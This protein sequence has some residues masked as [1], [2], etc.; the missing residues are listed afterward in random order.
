M[1]VL[2]SNK[3]IVR[4][5]K[6]GRP[7]MKPGHDGEFMYTGC[8]K[9][10]KL[11]YVLATRSFARIFDD[12]EQKEFEKL[13]NKKEGEL[14][15]YNWKSEFWNDF[16]VELGKEEKI[17]DLNIP[18]HALEYRVLKANSDKIAVDEANIRS[19]AH[20]YVL[21][22]ENAKQEADYKLSEKNE[23]AMELFMK[24]RKS[25]KKMYDLLRVLGKNPSHNMKSNTK[26]LKAELDA[27]IAQKERINGQVG[28]DDFIEAAKDPKFS[29][30]IF[31]LDAVEL[32]EILTKNGGYRIAET[33]QLIGNS[34]EQAVDF[35]D[36]A[37][38]QDQ[39]LLIEQRL[40]LNK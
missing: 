21:V 23:E 39:K 31:V 24:L 15:I 8:F 9:G 34:L 38:N 10:Y 1:S 3:V 2:N 5:V 6:S 30:K 37:K 17:L 13:L 28:I 11:P 27:V 33:K 22:D 14:S 40:Q 25:D 36:D 4:P 29:T 20:S 7:F 16:T 26:A 19:G 18:I 35:F 32:K 12:A